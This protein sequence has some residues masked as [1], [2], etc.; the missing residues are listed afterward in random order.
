MDPVACRSCGARFA[1]HDL[2]EGDYR[3]LQISDFG[4]RGRADGLTLA[5]GLG[6]R[7]F[8]RLTHRFDHRSELRCLLL[9]LGADLVRIAAI[10][11]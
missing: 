1:V 6:L 2:T 11:P 4:F 9:V 5:F 10:T 7:L 8:E 3:L